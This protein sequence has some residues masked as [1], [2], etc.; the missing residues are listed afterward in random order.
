M[1]YKIE[2]V[3]DGE[4]PYF[5]GDEGGVLDLVNFV[6]LEGTDLLHVINH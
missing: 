4:W 5:I 3:V 1:F 6:T 2:I